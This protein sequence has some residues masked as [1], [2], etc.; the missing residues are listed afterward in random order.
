MRLTPA[1]LHQTP[2]FVR[3]PLYDR[4]AQKCGIVHFGIGAF[5]RAHQAVYADAAMNAGDRDWKIIGVSPRSATVRDALA[6]QDGLYTVAERS[7]A[8]ETLRVV[9]AVSHVL[10]A[11]QAS[12][13]VIDAIA[14]PD[15]GIISFTITEQGYRPGAVL[16]YLAAGLA[17]RRAANLPGVTL[18]SCDNLAGNGA[19]LSTLL[20]DQLAARDPDLA[21][22]FL[23][24]C[25]A[26]STMVD[27]IVPAATPADRDQIAARIGLRDEAAVVTEPFH[28]W[29]IEDRFAGP[30]P[31]F[32]AAGARITA[33]IRPYETAKLRMLNG[34]H[35]ALAYLGLAHGH[36]FVHQA[37]ADPVIAPLVNRLM[38]DEAAAS[39]APAADQDLAAYAD[40][41]LVRFNNTAL[42]HRLAQIA[43][44]GSQKI[45]Q[46]WLE[47]LA[48]RQHHGVQCPALLTAMAAWLRFTRGDDHP[49]DDPM[50]DALKRLWTAHDPD[51]VVN[52]LFGPTGWFA[53]YWTPTA[54]DVGFLLGR[55]A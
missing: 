13:A 40:A 55:L 38:R 36:N 2:A 5:H 41:L 6:P 22:W 39:F 45:P 16:D 24:E 15:T 42:P 30:R 12:R 25:A 49:I 53:A 28:Q 11:P 4:A 20:T 37:I 26:P 51:G 54:G 48:D 43:T 17:A 29:V 9:G 44:D 10:F 52:A 1:G 50:A 23:D 31:R 34:A 47:T 33:D 3:R 46:R 32:E 18:L 27:R 21:R 35:S 8:G 7:Q 14:A 19:R